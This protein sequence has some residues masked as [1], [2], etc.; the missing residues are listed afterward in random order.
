GDFLVVVDNQYFFHEKARWA[1]RSG[2]R[3]FGTGQLAGRAGL[4][5][6]QGIRLHRMGFQRFGNGQQQFLR[7]VGL[8]EESSGTQPVGGLPKSFDL[9]GGDENDRNMGKAQALE[10][11]GDGEPEAYRHPNIHDDQVGM[12]IPGQFEPF[13]AVR[14]GQHFVAGRFEADA[15]GSRD[16]PVILHD[17]DF[18]LVGVHTSFAVAIY[19]RRGRCRPKW[20]RRQIAVSPERWT[21]RTVSITW[22][23]VLGLASRVKGE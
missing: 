12:L 18:F 11:L 7:V 10:P 21:L 6:E 3:A 13:K 14:G 22:L 4:T 23:A 15:Q 5:G 1:L 17:E 9:A 8:F 16:F 19:W 2:Q 20:F